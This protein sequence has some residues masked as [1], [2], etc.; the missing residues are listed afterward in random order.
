VAPSILQLHA[1][2]THPSSS[3]FVVDGS[4]A[5]F[6]SADGQ[7]KLVLNAWPS[8]PPVDA[9]SSMALTDLKQLPSM[10]RLRWFSTGDDQFWS[11]RL[12]LPINK[13]RHYVDKS[14]QDVA[15]PT[16]K[17]DDESLKSIF[18]RLIVTVKLDGWVTVWLGNDE[19]E[20]QLTEATQARKVDLDWAFGGFF[21]AHRSVSPC[22]DACG[23]KHFTAACCLYPP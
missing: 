7:H 5:Y 2:F 17:A 23:T 10:L 9:G 4:Q 19:Y 14:L 13:L 22:A 16:E 11:I 18:N 20:L 6:I 8:W 12:P 15:M 1:A 3:G 21:V